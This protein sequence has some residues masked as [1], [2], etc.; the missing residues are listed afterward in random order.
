ML[1]VVTVRAGDHFER[2]VPMPLNRA[3]TLASF[4]REWL[5]HFPGAVVTVTRQ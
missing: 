4:R 2:S 1:Y 3:E 5:A